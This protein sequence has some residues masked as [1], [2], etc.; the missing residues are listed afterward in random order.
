[1]GVVKKRIAVG[2]AGTIAVLGLAYL[3]GGAPEPGFDTK[4]K[5]ETAKFNPPTVDVW[6]AEAQAQKVLNEI[7]P[8][9]Q[10]QGKT[11]Q[12]WAEINSQQPKGYEVIGE[13]IG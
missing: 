4:P 8:E 12:A 9:C 13:C 11:A 1:M 5:F 7:T 2:V 10:A 6:E 3:P